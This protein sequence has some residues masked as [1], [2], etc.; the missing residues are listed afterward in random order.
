MGTSNTALRMAENFILR[1]ITNDYI[2]V[3][4]NTNPEKITYIDTKGAA[5]FKYL[6]KYKT[7][8]ETSK[9]LA[10]KYK[11]TIK[12]AEKTLR[13]FIDNITNTVSEIT[14]VDLEE[15]TQNNFQKKIPFTGS[16]EVT[17]R[18]NLRCKHCYAVGERIKQ[19]LSFNQIKKIIDQLAHEGCLFL[20]LTGGECTFH[21][22]FIKIYE[23]IRKKGIIPS[24]STNATLLSK[25]LL[26]TLNKY[27]PHY[28]KISLYGSDAKTHE[29]IT[30]IKGSFEKVINNA[31]KLKKLGIEVYFTGVI[32]KENYHD[33]SNIKALADKLEIPIFFYSQLIPTLNLD[34]APLEM[35]INKKLQKT[36]TSFNSKVEK[37]NSPRSNFHMNDKYFS[38]NAGTSSFHLDSQGN[39]FICKVERNNGISLLTTNLREAWE[40]LNKISYDLLKYPTQCVEC[41]SLKKCNTCPIKVS[42]ANS[43]KVPY[44]FCNNAEGGDIENIL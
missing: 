2:L 14:D 24:I 7:L 32:F 15:K 38:C 23:Y 34:T 39:L 40:K 25:E 19:S 13:D 36:V 1:K 17:G 3:P 4:L 43:A 22:D 16:F 8:K 12:E 10:I 33:I 21:K 30:R 26:T 9:N 28:I 27:P 6:I 20:Q 44:W 42:L 31:Q 35:S 41:S 37:F 5:F 29:A 11:V 18:C